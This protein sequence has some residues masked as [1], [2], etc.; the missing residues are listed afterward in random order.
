MSGFSSFHPKPDSPF[1]PSEL[2]VCSVM[3]EQT[4]GNRPDS[5]EKVVLALR[6]KH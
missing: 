2:P 5:V 6:V 3:Q 1:A 4:G